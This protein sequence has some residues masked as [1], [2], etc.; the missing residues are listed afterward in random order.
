MTPPTTKKVWLNAGKSTLLCCQSLPGDTQQWVTRPPGA[1]IHPTLPQQLVA[2][3]SVLPSV[4]LSH[5]MLPLKSL[6]QNSQVGCVA[7]WDAAVYL[8]VTKQWL[9][10]VP[11]LWMCCGTYECPTAPS[12]LI[13][14]NTKYR[15]L[16][17]CPRKAKFALNIQPSDT[18]RFPF[19]LCPF[20]DQK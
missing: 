2:V 1:A 6:S 3:L 13:T 17:F 16:A 19:S 15:Q 9:M 4:Q 18:N 12:L 11:H 10:N 7:P 14:R 5:V 20:S 8:E